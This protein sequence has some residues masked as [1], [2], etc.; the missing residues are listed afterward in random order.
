MAASSAE[1]LL[2]DS[3][4]S[5]LGIIELDLCLCHK[6]QIPTVYTKANLC[7][8]LFSWPHAQTGSLIYIDPKYLLP[9][10]APVVKQAQ[11]ECAH[12]S[13]KHK[14]YGSSNRPRGS[15]DGSNKKK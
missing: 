10:N 14:T 11:K 4:A 13:R 6:T 5:R 7:S 12:R 2:M 8:L 9:E 3:N 15:L 1:A